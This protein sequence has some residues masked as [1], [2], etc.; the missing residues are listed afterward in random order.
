M[1]RYHMASKF[2][3][4]PIQIWWAIPW[5]PWPCCRNENFNW[6]FGFNGPPYL[7]ERNFKNIIKI[8]VISLIQHKMHHIKEPGQTDNS[9]LL[10]NEG[11][12]REEKQQNWTFQCICHQRSRISRCHLLLV[13]AGFAPCN[14]GTYGSM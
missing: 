8:I 10:A 13:L 12:F 2:M 3:E 7:A 9:K 11:R 1:Y 4:S 6:L 5:N 14:S